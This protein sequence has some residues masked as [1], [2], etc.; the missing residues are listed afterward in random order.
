MKKGTA[1]LDIP[2]A[3]TAPFKKIETRY[4]RLRLLVCKNVRSLYFKLIM[5]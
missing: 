3:T 4:K 5:T 1:V 2:K